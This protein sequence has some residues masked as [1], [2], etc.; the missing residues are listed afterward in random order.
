LVLYSE[1]LRRARAE[2][3]AMVGNIRLPMFEDRSS[4]SFLEPTPRNA[5][6]APVIAHMSPGLAHLE[7]EAD[8]SEGYQMPK[9]FSW[10]V[11]HGDVPDANDFKAE[12]LLNSDGT[13]NHDTVSYAF[14]FGSSI[15]LDRQFADGSLSS[16]IAMIISVLAVFEF[17]DRQ[18]H[19]TEPRWI[20]GITRYASG[21]LTELAIVALLIPV[22]S[23]CPVSVQHQ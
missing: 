18:P 9:D 1:A 10:R 16:G 14:G 17:Q 15:C 13:L 11:T 2:M 3:D 20:S 5:Q 12:R 21:V 8:S 7:P 19:F 4:V 22:Q 6:V 23:S